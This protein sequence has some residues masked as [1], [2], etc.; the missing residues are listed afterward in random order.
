[1]ANPSCYIRLLAPAHWRLVE[2]PVEGCPP[3]REGRSPHARSVP[4]PGLTHC[5]RMSAHSSQQPQTA[6]ISH[7]CQTNR[8]SSVARR[9]PAGAAPRRMR[10]DILWATCLREPPRSRA[11]TEAAR[12]L[13]IRSI[14]R[15]GGPA[16]RRP[17]QMERRGP[18]NRLAGLSRGIFK[19]KQAPAQETSTADEGTGLRGPEAPQTCQWS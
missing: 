6:A 14:A 13:F 18:G 5:T 12:V 8:I 7:L 2:V 4:E 17:R 9:S 1:M 11:V 10:S 19:R 3:S 16:G 15:Q